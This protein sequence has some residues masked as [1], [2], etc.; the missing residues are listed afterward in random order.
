M[1]MP[2]IAD[3]SGQRFGRLIAVRREVVPRRSGGTLSRWVCRCDCGNESRTALGSLRRGLAKSC[4]CWQS[5]VTTARSL[6]H[7]HAYSPTYSSWRGMID[8]CT[9]PNNT[10]FAYYGGR[11][12]TV[13]DEWKDFR[14]FLTDMGVRPQGMTLDRID[15]NRG[16]EAANCK[17]STYRAQA[18]NRRARGTSR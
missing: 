14:N 12:I 11:G 7:G 10:K 3:I 8:R 17:W 13:C 6:K 5:D 16:Y 15:G 1:V 4:G 9:N 18:N 2:Q